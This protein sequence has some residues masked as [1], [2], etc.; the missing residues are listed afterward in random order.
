MNLENVKEELSFLAPLFDNS[1]RYVGAKEIKPVNVTFEEFC[2]IV[3][4]V[5]VFFD[6]AWLLISHVF[7]N[8]QNEKQDISRSIRPNSKADYKTN[9]M[10]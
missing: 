5:H 2:Q 8:P 7:L 9:Q 10:I 4:S 6:V 3:C 1:R